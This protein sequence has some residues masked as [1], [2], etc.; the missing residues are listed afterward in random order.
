MLES[1]LVLGQDIDLNYHRH[2]LLLLEKNFPQSKC[3]LQL[4]LYLDRCYLLSG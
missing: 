3:Q 4:E 1:A 2:K